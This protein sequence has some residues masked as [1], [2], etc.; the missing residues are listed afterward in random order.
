MECS[1]TSPRSVAPEPYV[2]P[3]AEFGDDLLIKIFG[4]VLGPLEQGQYCVNN[5]AIPVGIKLKYEHLEPTHLQHFESIITLSQV[6]S[7]FLTL[8][9]HLGG[10]G[11]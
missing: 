4:F 1:V 5:A 6:L 10:T 9:R 7:H 8:A 2:I 11:Q 3:L